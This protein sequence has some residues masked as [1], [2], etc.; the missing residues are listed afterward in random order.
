M[1]TDLVWGKYLSY[2][3]SHVAPKAQKE[4]PKAFPDGKGNSAVEVS[5]GV[6]C[7][8]FLPRTRSKGKVQNQTSMFSYSENC[9]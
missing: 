8:V 3:S 1:L 7:A 5:T 6:T 4:S 9:I 2:F